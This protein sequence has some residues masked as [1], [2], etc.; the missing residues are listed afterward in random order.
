[1]VGRTRTRPAG[2]GGRVGV[3]VLRPCPASASASAY[4]AAALPLA[5]LPGA[6]GGAGGGGGGGGALSSPS[7]QVV[8]VV[9]ADVVLVEEVVDVHDGEL[10]VDRVEDGERDGL[11]P[12]LGT[13]EGGFWVRGRNHGLALM[14]RKDE[15]GLCISR[16]I[17]ID[18]D[19]QPEMF[20]CSC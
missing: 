20:F 4:A 17:S 19:S 12:Q 10:C 16:N 3:R 5:A 11:V 7:H 1:M 6:G 8:L 2:G 15:I 14:L 13:Q 9:K 18:E